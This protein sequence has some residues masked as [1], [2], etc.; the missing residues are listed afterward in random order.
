MALGVAP[1]EEL[2]SGRKEGQVVLS[3]G[4][5]RKTS[6]LHVGVSEDL[7]SQNTF[8]EPSMVKVVPGH[9]EVP[10]DNRLVTRILPEPVGYLLPEFLHIAT[11][12]LATI[13]FFEGA[14]VQITSAAA[15]PD[16]LA[17]GRDGMG[18]EHQNRV[19]VDLGRRDHDSLLRPCVD[20][21]PG[22]RIHRTRW[23]RWGDD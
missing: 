11:A 5:I 22:L 1:A 9:V 15:G 4:R 16:L 8:Q 21:P 19:A 17:R 18:H 6:G 13:T 23:F 7:E 12:A 14:T 3:I 2:V 10:H 20:P